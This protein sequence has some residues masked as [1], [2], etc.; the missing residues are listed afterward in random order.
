MATVRLG[1]RQKTHDIRRF[2]LRGVAD[3]SNGIAARTADE[4]G[5]AIATVN[6][7]VRA[8]VAEGNL[9]SEGRTRSRIYRLP[10][11]EQN[12]FTIPLDK[13]QD[14]S[15]VWERLVAPRLR[16]VRSNVQAVCQHGFTEMLNNA[17]DHSESP[18]AQVTVTRNAVNIDLV[19]SDS[20]IGIFQKIAD[21]LNLESPQQ[22]LIELAKGKVTTDPDR[23]SG[24][25][26]FFTSRMFHRFAILSGSLLFDHDPNSDWLIEQESGRVRRGTHVF[27]T[28]DTESELTTAEVFDR[29][30]SERQEYGFTKT[31][32]PVRM[33]LH[34]G[35]RLVSRSQARRLLS[36]VDR[37]SKVMLDFS[38]VDEIG[39][40]FADE[41][42]RVF[43]RSNPEIEL[44]PLKASQAVRNMIRRA[45]NAD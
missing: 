16:N 30:T 17:I 45:R 27:M 36:R 15:D 31:H 33:M 5:L 22:S 18:I 12:T 24:E 32:V 14:E 8:L 21:S 42:F 25:G 34:E 6:G 4:F 20:G 35:D 39:Q 10:I 40:A 44:V 13:P 11:L 23:H 2:I 28:I 1:Q 38:G 9:L 3:S 43:A 7:H 37:F 29:F 26:I 41:I 19:V